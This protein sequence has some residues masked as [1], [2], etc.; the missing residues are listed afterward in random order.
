M[1]IDLEERSVI[2]AQIDE[3][4]DKAEKI[5]GPSRVNCYDIVKKLLN[6]VSCEVEERVKHEILFDL[7]RRIIDQENIA[8]KLVSEIDKNT[9]S[10]TFIIEHEYE[11][12]VACEKA[13][14]D[15]A[16]ETNMN[17]DRLLK[18]ATQRER[19]LS[20]RTVDEHMT[21]VALDII[22]LNGMI[23][24]R[25]GELTPKVSELC[26]KSPAVRGYILQSAAY[27]LRNMYESYEFYETRKNSPKLN[28]KAHEI[29]KK[30][31]ND[32]EDVLK[33]L[34]ETNPKRYNELKE[35]A[36][37]QAIVRLTQ[38]ENLV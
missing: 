18:V 35:N 27:R 3:I 12:A 24:S 15:L 32:Y 37:Y 33:E 28:K 23:Y 25:G 8:E 11:K 19:N 13:V 22:V 36:Y 29:A 38:E 7:I 17:F 4:I 26:K 5:A 10:K 21:D 30:F 6:E 34:K 2:S 9:G 31:K 20:P 1:G 16:N 14:S